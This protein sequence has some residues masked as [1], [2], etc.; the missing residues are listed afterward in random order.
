VGGQPKYQRKVQ[1]APLFPTQRPPLKTSEAE[2]SNRREKGN[3]REK[4]S[5]GWPQVTRVVKVPEF[6]E[7]EKRKHKQKKPSDAKKHQGMCQIHDLG[8]SL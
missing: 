2:G 7:Q 1:D 3:K 4:K 6:S 8:M 5:S